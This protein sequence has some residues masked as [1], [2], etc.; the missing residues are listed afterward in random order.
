ML[1]AFAFFLLSAYVANVRTWA[2]CFVLGIAVTYFVKKYKG[3]TVL[4]KVIFS[5]IPLLAIA[6]TFAFLLSGLTTD[7]SALGRIDQY[8]TVPVKIMERPAGLGFGDVGPK[9][10]I[11][12]DSNI[13]TL[14]FAFGIVGAILYIYLTLYLF[15]RLLDHSV[16]IFDKNRVNIHYKVLY[17]SM[18][19]YGAAYIY[20]SA[21]QYSLFY[22]IQYLIFILIALL[23]NRFAEN[24]RPYAKTVVLTNEIQ[25]CERS[26]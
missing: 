11:S 25:V 16:V 4:S 20:V 15:F 5:V 2:I 1:F 23:L 3:R 14:P 12:A 7:L 9:G 6:A 26:K 8:I 22:G 17:L 24:K 21:F 19:S 10:S 18:I 13:L